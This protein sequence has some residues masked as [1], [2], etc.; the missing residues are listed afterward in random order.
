MRSP[1]CGAGTRVALATGR[2]G[3]RSNVAPRKEKVLSSLLGDAGPPW[4]AT[5]EGASRRGTR[6][7]RRLE[8]DVNDS[9][10]DELGPVDYVVVEFP[11]DKA[12]F[13]G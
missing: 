2:I 12:N 5:L 11:A 4:S 10:G 1:R 8:D 7:K 9:D 3:D 13:S 6:A